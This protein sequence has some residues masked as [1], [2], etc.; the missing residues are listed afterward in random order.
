MS[1]KNSIYS[2]PQAGREQAEVEKMLDEVSELMTDGEAGKLASTAFWGNSEMKAATRAAYDRFQGWNALF[3]FQEAGAARL[4]NDVIDICIGLAGGDGESRGNLTSGGTESNFCAL[5]A[6][7]AW[8]RETKPHI[9]TPNIVAP[10]SIHATVHKV[11]QVLDIEVKTVDQSPTEPINPQALADAIDENTIGL[12]GSA[13]NWPFGQIDPIEAMGQIAIERDLW[14]HVDACVG[15]YILPFFRDLGEDLP[16]YDLSVPGV[17][18]M[19]GDMHKYGYAPKPLSTILWKSAEEQRYHFIPISNWPCGLYL[20]QSLVGSRPLAPTAAAWSLFHKLGRDG[21]RANA[22]KILDT[23][24]RIIDA[25]AEIEGLTTWPTHGPL[26]Q[27]AEDGIDVMLVVGG[28]EERGWRLLG[29][30]EPPA[31]H[32]TVDVMTPTSLEKFT[33]DLIEVATLIR[34]GEIKSEGLLSYG[35]VGAEE[36]APKWLLSAVELMGEEEH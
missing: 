4:E 22:K 3:A 35:G 5:Q 36:T 9:K 26:L 18:S 7:R 33:T 15:A 24:N 13:P 28:M 12:A 16:N 19:S 17:R 31:I 21:Y 27:I 30:N 23:R 29:V 6:M 14:L 32:L 8:T 34:A 10:Y 11:A 2:L 20:S 25:V 1:I